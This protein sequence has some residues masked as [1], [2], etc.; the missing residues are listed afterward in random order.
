MNVTKYESYHD[1][2]KKRR[3]KMMLTLTHVRNEQRVVDE[4]KHAIDR[5]AYKSRLHLL[6]NLAD[7][8][9][10]ETARIDEALTRIAEGKYGICLGCREP[11][12]ARRLEAAPEAMFCAACQ[13]MREKLSEA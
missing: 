7:W 5:S 2:L 10:K 9:A 11:I 12:D 4:N 1:L 8:Y 13:T 3:N 6:G